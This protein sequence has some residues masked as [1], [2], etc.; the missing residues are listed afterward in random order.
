MLFTLH[1]YVVLNVPLSTEFT[2]ANLIPDL[3]QCSRNVGGNREDKERNLGVIVWQAQTFPAR[4]II[5]HLCH[6][7]SWTT[8][9]KWNVYFLVSN[10]SIL[11]LTKCRIKMYVFQNIKRFKNYEIRFIIN[12]VSCYLLTCSVII[13]HKLKQ[14]VNMNT[15]WL[16]YT[17]ID[18]NSTFNIL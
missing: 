10:K 4:G 18:L 5:F 14:W 13:F 6:W 17:T 16:H 2:I 15:S 3:T 8:R 11:L 12:I 1:L 7:F 9:R